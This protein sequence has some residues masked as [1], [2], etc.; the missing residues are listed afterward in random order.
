VLTTVILNNILY[1][2]LIKR[3]HKYHE[4]KFGAEYKSYLDKVI[5][6]LL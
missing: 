2:V 5:I 4:E 3:E 6:K 1:S